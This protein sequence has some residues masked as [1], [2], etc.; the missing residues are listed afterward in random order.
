MERKKK[1]KM[2]QGLD[3]TLGARSQFKDGRVH[4][5]VRWGERGRGGVALKV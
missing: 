1:K 3:K 2:K 5:S 4:A